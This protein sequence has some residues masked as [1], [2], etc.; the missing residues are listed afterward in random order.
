MEPRADVPRV[1][2]LSGAAS[3]PAGGWS[4]GWVE[5]LVVA[6]ALILAP[7]PTELAAQEAVPVLLV[8]GWSDTERDLAPL[9]IRLLS[10]GWR[11]EDVISVS[12]QDPEGSNLDH[13]D[14]LRAVAD[15]VV[16]ARGGSALHIVA[17]S[18]GGLAVRAY[19]SGGGV[20][21]R[22][23]FLATPHQGTWSAYLGWGEGAEEM[24]PG[25]RFLADLPTDPALP[26]GVEAVTV[27]TPLDT[28]ILPSESATLPGV[29]DET[30][31]CPTHTGLLRDLEAFRV[32]RRFLADGVVTADGA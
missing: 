20:A 10:A 24:I 21:R 1:R 7:G 8:P 26:V 23:V 29:P 17:H 22:V 3:A 16:A 13:A 4:L 31:C 32:I 18:M 5:A 14:E 19:L 2:G 6:A 28:H 30:V 12:F 15:S 27:R 25:S 9:R 11:A